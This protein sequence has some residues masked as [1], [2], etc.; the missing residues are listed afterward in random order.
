MG[1]AQSPT[2][3]APVTC[4]LCGKPVTPDGLG[5]LECPCGWGGPGDP[6]ETS[7][8]L[9]RVFLWTGRR[10]ANAQAQ[11]EL[12]RLKDRGDAASRLSGVYEFTIALVSSLIYA[13]LFGA[14]AWIIWFTIELVQAH[15]WV[16]ATL[17]G[18]VALALLDSLF[19]QTRRPKGLE[20]PLDRLPALAAV[21]DG[22]S[23]HIGSPRPQFVVL[24]PDARFFVYQ[25]HPIKRFF[26]RELVL[27]VG[28]AGLT[29]LN[30]QE[31]QAIL[32]HE[33]AHFAYGHTA[34]TLYTGRAL[35]STRHLIDLALGGV[36]SMDRYHR[37]R[38]RYYSAGIGSGT[39]LA[40]TFISWTVLLPFRCLW[41]CL[42]LLRLR[43]SRTAEYAA[44]MAAA[45]L[46][47]A[48]LFVSAE[49]NI[50]MIARTLR[51]ARQSLFAELRRDKHSNFYEV[52]RRHYAG[53]PP[54]AV[55]QMRRQAITG[56][57]SLESTHP[58]LPDRLR[59]AYIIGGMHPVAPPTPTRA[60]TVYL[61]P[62]DAASAEEMEKAVTKLMFV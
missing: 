15:S 34:L 25:R 2:G 48:P 35:A 38:G 62:K 54:A 45:R 41:T 43:L 16:G 12:R 5:L 20:M 44:D 49:I 40:G 21:V 53:L 1:V 58:I 8:G 37:M 13:L 28:V 3:A 57:R 27:G 50:H 6:L 47:G 7:R 26:R 24:V 56:F 36:Q 32:A 52:L 33:L 55:E 19:G 4:R 39:A 23:A 11:R 59:A 17:L 46:F 42:H 29:V 22:M 31:V 61:I 10:L 18:L 30:D 14:L 60:G 51:G 9:S